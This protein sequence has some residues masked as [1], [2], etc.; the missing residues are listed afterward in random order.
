MTKACGAKTK[1]GKPCRRQTARG[2]C[3][4]HAKAHKARAQGEKRKRAY[5]PTPVPRSAPVRFWTEEQRARLDVDKATQQARERRA[6]L[7]YN[8]LMEATLPLGSGGQTGESFEARSARRNEE[9][10]DA[11]A[12]AARMAQEMGLPPPPEAEDAWRDFYG[13]DAY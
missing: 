5:S 10:M 1:S 11:S 9:A 3:R 12:R 7:E 13:D 2:R 8:R 6:R 4:D